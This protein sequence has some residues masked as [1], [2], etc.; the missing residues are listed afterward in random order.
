[1]V[2]RPEYWWVIFFLPMLGSWWGWDRW[3]HHKRSQRKR[4]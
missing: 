4:G 1:V 3:F 2:L